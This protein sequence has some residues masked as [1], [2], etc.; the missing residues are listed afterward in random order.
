ML[1]RGHDE[2]VGGVAQQVR[3]L[4]ICPTTVSERRKIEISSLK[5]LRETAT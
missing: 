4:I 5:F 1:P 2:Q 3:R